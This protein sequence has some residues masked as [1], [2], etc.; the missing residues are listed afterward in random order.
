[1]IH[2]IALVAA[3]VL[4]LWNIPL[5][6]R[7]IKRK[8]AKDI[9]LYWVFGVWVCMLAMFPAGIVSEDIV[10]KTFNICNIILFSC[11]VACT[12]TYYRR[13]A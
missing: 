11:V 7:M 2:K 12:V 5:I 10:W 6:M 1:M 4:P 13:E 8:S 3:V 9:S